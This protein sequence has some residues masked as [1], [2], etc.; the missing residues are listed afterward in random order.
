M[1]L[2]VTFGLRAKVVRP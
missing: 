1:K 2:D